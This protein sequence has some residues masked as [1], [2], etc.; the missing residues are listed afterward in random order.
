M[1][2]K[3]ADFIS[4]KN[5][6]FKEELS[7]AIAKEMKVQ[8]PK[9]VAEMSLVEIL[10]VVPQMQEWLLYRIVWLYTHSTYVTELQDDLREIQHYAEAVNFSS[11]VLRVVYSHINELKKDKKALENYCRALV[12]NQFYRVGKKSAYR[13]RFL[14]R[15]VM[16]EVFI[17]ENGYCPVG[18]MLIIDEARNVFSVQFVPEL[19]NFL[20]NKRNKGNEAT[21]RLR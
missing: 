1:E 6:R 21:E 12:G 7:E 11:M 2:K 9:P 19:Q 13:F 5:F 17:E 16:L 15:M 10:A 14:S 20:Q 3:L 18:E 8:M 4:E